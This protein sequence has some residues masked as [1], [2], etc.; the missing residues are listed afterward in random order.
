MLILST[1]ILAIPL[2]AFV[3][4]SALSFPPL[5]QAA[6]VEPATLPALTGVGTSKF[7]TDPSFGGGRV[8]LT[9]QPKTPAANRTSFSNTRPAS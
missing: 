1:C 8:L 4:S 3:E 2:V 7:L 5:R 9:N 6:H